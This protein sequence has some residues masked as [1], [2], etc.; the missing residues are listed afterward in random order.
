[1]TL[2]SERNASEVRLVEYQEEK[3]TVST[4]EFSAQQEWRLHPIVNVWTTINTKKANNV[5]MKYSSFSAAAK[6]SRRPQFF[7]WNI[8][9]V[10]VISQ[11][12]SFLFTSD[13]IC[14]DQKQKV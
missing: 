5:V 9:M 1:M 3:S 8:I 12:L 14:S 11:I 13:S 7:I 6:A 10:M 2:V 4:E